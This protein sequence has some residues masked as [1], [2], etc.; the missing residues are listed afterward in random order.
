MNIK[1]ELLFNRMGF[2]KV[3]SKRTGRIVYVEAS[4]Y[5]GEY[6]IWGQISPTNERGW[7]FDIDDLEIFEK[8]E[9]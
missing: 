8:K 7:Y 6:M 2:V 4:N 3:R 1:D 5:G 9:D